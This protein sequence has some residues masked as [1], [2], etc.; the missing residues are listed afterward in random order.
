MTVETDTFPKQISEYFP[1]VPTPIDAAF[2]YS[3]DENIYFF[4]DS[5]FWKYNHRIAPPVSDPKP[6]YMWPGIPENG[7]DAAVSLSDSYGNNFT[8][9]FKDNQYWKFNDKAYSVFLSQ[10]PYPKRVSTHLFGCREWQIFSG[11]TG[12]R[13]SQVYGRIS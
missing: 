4:K 11:M 10:P 3:I 8:Y 9:F 1:G 5:Q 2:V 12:V 6:I 13:Y 7:L